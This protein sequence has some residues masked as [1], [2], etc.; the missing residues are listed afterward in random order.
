VQW[1]YGYQLT[2]DDNNIITS[3]TYSNCLAS[4]LFDN[5]KSIANNIALYHNVEID[6]SW[7]MK[8]VHTFSIII[9]NNNNLNEDTTDIH[10]SIGQMKTLKR[11]EL[12]TYLNNTLVNNY[13]AIYQIN[14]SYDSWPIKDTELNDIGFY[15]VSL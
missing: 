4:T 8:S 3:R 15:Y 11:A 7:K 14:T 5:S 12:L 6:N 13:G 9:N 10:E 1:N 2:L